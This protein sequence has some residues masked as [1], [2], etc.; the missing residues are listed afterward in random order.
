LRNG[1]ILFVA[2]NGEIVELDATFKQVRSI[3]PEAHGNG[4]GYW[5]SIEPLPNGRFLVALGTSGKV[6][7]VDAKGKIQWQCDCTNAVFATRLRNGNTLV[8]NFE[9][10][11]LLEFDRGGKEVNRI[12]LAGR[13]FVFKRY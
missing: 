4:A 1:N 9:G 6:V 13:P 5:A 7:E 10:R 11:M 2:A 3:T 12:Q 8:S